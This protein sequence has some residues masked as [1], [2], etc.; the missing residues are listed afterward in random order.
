M[1][2]TLALTWHGECW[3][4]IDPNAGGFLAQILAPLGAVFLSFLFYCRRQIRRSV[5]SIRDRWK[6]IESHET[7]P[8]AKE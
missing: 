4:Y 5:K 2:L 1:A 3:A 8:E 7:A 6:G